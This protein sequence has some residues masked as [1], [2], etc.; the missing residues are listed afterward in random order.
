MFH[1]SVLVVCAFAAVAHSAKIDSLS[2]DAPF[3]SV[4]HSDDGARVVPGFRAQG[5]TDIHK[6]FV[7]LTP[8]RQSKAGTLWSEGSFE[9]AAA[10][11]SAALT[12]RISGQASRWFGD[13]IG[14]WFTNDQGYHKA[15]PLHGA[16]DTFTGFGVIVDTF[17][18]TESLS[19]HNDITIFVNN[20]TRTVDDMQVNS[21][22]CNP[23][24]KLRFHEKRADFAWD[25]S[26]RVSVSVKN[27][28]LSVMVD[29][30]NTGEWTECVAQQELDLPASF[31]EGEEVQVGVSASTGGVADNHD[32]ISMTTY[33]LA[34]EAASSQT[35]P[36]PGSDEDGISQLKHHLEHELI[37]LKE[38]L[39]NTIG[40]LQQ[41]EK[42]AEVRIEVLEQ[43]LKERVL[44]ETNAKLMDMVLKLQKQEDESQKFVMTLQQQEA[45]SHQRI[46]ALE[47]RLGN[48][49][50]FTIERHASSIQETVD[51]RLQSAERDTSSWK[52]PF[53]LLVL[54]LAGGGYGVFNWYQ[55]M[56]KSHLL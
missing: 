37:H 53:M 30:R 20:G 51:Q 8:D 19:K 18:N 41:A 25:V 56:R 3:D 31:Y 29:E 4:Q 34:E 22:G 10:E 45:D 52:M 44:E 14:W 39:G 36:S 12:F 21:F 43:S 15:G 49:L 55:G 40:K 23:G 24:K 47:Q 50:N 26:S 17:E 54:A 42:E 7:R 32:V 46:N 1:N 16:A 38:S 33:T 48:V 28:K 35:I 2:F 6:H 13:G 11:F 5:N 9:P 27:G